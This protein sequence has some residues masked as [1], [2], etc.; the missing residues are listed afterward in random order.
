MCVS[1]FK[2]RTCSQTVCV[3]K[4]CSACRPNRRRDPG[5]GASPKH[6]PPLHPENRGRQLPVERNQVQPSTMSKS[7]IKSGEKIS[8][9]IQSTRRTACVVEQK[10]INARRISGG[11]LSRIKSFTNF[12]T[13][14]CFKYCRLPVGGRSSIGAFMLTC[15]VVRSKTKTEGVAITLEG[16]SFVIEGVK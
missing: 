4:R 6:L 14:N 1:Q 3:C 2:T 15:R 10:S 13:P 7:S 16:E 5:D 12:V 9:S 8:V 11:V